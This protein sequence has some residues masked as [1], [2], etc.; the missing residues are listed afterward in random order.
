MKIRGRKQKKELAAA[1]KRARD[2]RGMEQDEEARE[3]LQNAIERFPG[4][5]ELRLLYATILLMIRPEDVAPEAAKAVELA[6]DDPA[7]LVRAGHLLLHRGDLEAARSC[8]ARASRLAE[9]DFVLLSA[10]E[11]L[12]GRLAALSGE[13]GIAEEQL[14]SAAARDPLYSTFA[15]DLA[16]FLA[17]RGRREEALEVIDEALACAEEKADLTRLRTEITEG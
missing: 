10:L 17:S 1:I 12:K 7:I 14:R 13:D 16:E 9:P 3:F 5:A 8:A 6:P 11:S 2:L 15:I 4:N